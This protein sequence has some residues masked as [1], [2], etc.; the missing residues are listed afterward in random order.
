MDPRDAARIGAKPG[1]TEVATAVGSQAAL[2]LAAEPVSWDRSLKNYR[3]KP[4]NPD[5]SF[6]I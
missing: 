4:E 5:L 1:A 3:R 6:R 2:L